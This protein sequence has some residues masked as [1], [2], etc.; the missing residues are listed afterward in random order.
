MGDVLVDYPQRLGLFEQ[1]VSGRE[2]ADHARAL[3][4]RQRAALGPR[5]LFRGG[6][7]RGRNGSLGDAFAV[8]AQVALRAFGRGCAGRGTV[9]RAAFGDAGDVIGGGEAVLLEAAFG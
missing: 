1:D 2:L 7:L 5:G 9:R 3:Q 6:R 8:F 4:R